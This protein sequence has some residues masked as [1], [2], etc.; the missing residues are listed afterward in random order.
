MP[1]SLV[2]TQN[3]SLCSAQIIFSS[4]YL[5]CIYRLLEA[6]SPSDPISYNNNF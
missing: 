2:L 5:V 4:S 3:N 1:T 6:V